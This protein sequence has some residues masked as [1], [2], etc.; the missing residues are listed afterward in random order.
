MSPIEVG[1]GALTTGAGGLLYSPN[2]QEVTRREGPAGKALLKVVLS[3][4]F[5]W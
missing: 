3:C 1:G 5:S 2:P 4:V